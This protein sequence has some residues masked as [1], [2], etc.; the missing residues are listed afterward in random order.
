M[1][2]EKCTVIYARILVN[3]MELS[4]SYR[5]TSLFM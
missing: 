2:G 4:N 1:H 3:F 5:D